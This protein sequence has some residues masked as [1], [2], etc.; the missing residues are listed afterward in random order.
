MSEGGFKRNEAGLWEAYI[1]QDRA[2]GIRRSVGWINGDHR[3]P[4]WEVFELLCVVMPKHKDGGR[5]AFANV[6]FATKI[7]E[8]LNDGTLVP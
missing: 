6:P 1:A 4:R 3:L 7:V 5:E 8:M 2:I